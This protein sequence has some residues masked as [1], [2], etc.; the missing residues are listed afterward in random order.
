MLLTIS[1]LF[2]W[3]F[4]RAPGA[5]FA[6]AYQIPPIEADATMPIEILIARF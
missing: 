6:I 1:D 4:P 5:R 2:L 3:R